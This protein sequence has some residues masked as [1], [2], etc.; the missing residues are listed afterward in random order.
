MDLR[1][2]RCPQRGS[3]LPPLQSEEELGELG[4]AARAEGAGLEDLATVAGVVTESLDIRDP[5]RY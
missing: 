3:P 1:V 5:R 4:P 2:C